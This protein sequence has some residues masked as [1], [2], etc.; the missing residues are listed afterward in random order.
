MTR[1]LIAILRGISRVEAAPAARA[2]IDAGITQIEVP[3]N[4][5]D[6]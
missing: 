6:P 5:P 4:S 1:P 2:L 3:L